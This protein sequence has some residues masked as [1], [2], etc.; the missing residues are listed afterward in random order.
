[1]HFPNEQALLDCIQE[2]RPTTMNIETRF[3]RNASDFAL[4]WPEIQS[5][6][7][8]LNVESDVL[9]NPVHFLA[10]TDD[11]RRPCSVGCWRGTRFLGLLYATEHFVRGLGIG[12]AVG[13][14]FTGRGLLLCAPEDEAAVLKAA[15][16]RMVSEGIH[17]FH[18]RLLPKDQSRFAMKGLD[19]KFLDALIPGDRIALKSDFE[20]FLGGLGKN[21]RR[22]V[23]AYT[24]KTEELG[25]S[26]I[27]ELNENQ[28]ADAVV[29]LNARS[30]FPADDLHISRDER[31][32]ALH[33][34]GERMGLRSPEGVLI[35]VL[36]GFRQGNR[37]HLLTQ[38][39]DRNYER[40]SLSLVLRGHMMK[41][42][43]ECGVLELQFMGGS[44]LSFGRFCEPQTYR[45]LFI[46]KKTGVAAA[47]K[48]S[49]I[50]L[51]AIM[52]SLGRPVPEALAVICNGLLDESTLSSRT[53]LKPASIV[54]EG[55]TAPQT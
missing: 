24:R 48:Q 14:D 39:N 34:G 54:F 5:L 52:T 37:F 20:E 32:L 16:T 17:S 22:N 9:L 46:D 36:C 2:R 42:L 49:C 53:V 25:I 19:M 10:S 3:L 50:K 8:K 23:R 30:Q 45:S 28:Y 12:Y 18:L 51:I 15:I 35:S 13:G 31:L 7:R 33:R 55:R 11:T 26:F 40:L 44:S 4:C 41:H 38:F 1:V 27:E 29:R 21:T 47:L 43:I 6:R